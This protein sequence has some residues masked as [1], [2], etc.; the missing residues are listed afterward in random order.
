LQ[1]RGH[2]HLALTQKFQGLTSIQVKKRFYRPWRRASSM[3]IQHSMPLLWTRTI[4]SSSNIAAIIAPIKFITPSF[5]FS[6]ANNVS[7]IF[8]HLF[9]ILVKVVK[10]TQ[11]GYS[12]TIIL[13]VLSLDATD[14][15][16][17]TRLTGQK[18]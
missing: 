15:L 4:L 6:S 10:F 3:D 2:F 9:T 12:L 17:K 1:K 14:K 18:D 8:S 11:N 16:L 5:L 13:S 7:F